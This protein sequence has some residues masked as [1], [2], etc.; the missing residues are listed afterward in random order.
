MAIKKPNPIDIQVGAR[1]RMLRSSVGMSQSALGNAIGLTFQQIQKY[2][3][4]TNRMGSSRLQ[5]IANVLKVSPTF[6]FEDA[7][8]KFKTND[9]S[10]ATAYLYEFIS[11][12][13]GDAIMRAFVKLRSTAVRRS[14]VTLVKSIAGKE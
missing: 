5:Q 4:G 13:D 14:I 3:K 1:V 7:P 2:E 11:S 8:G 9:K 10:S 12:A 6:F